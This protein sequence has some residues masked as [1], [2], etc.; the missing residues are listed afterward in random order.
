MLGAIIGDI[1]GSRFEFN[2]HRSKE[3]ELFT[4]ECFVT[5]DSIMTLAVAK[6]LM[7]TEK[8][9]KLDL[10]SS[11]NADEYYSILEKMT[12]TYMQKI[13]R[14]YPNCGYGG[15][16]GHW[17]FSDHPKPYNSFG[18]GAA[19]RISS[20]AFVAKDES[21]VV[22]LSET[23][24]GVTHN[25][26]EGYKGAEATAIAVW[27][28]R[29]GYTKS[30]IRRQINHNYY[31][32]NYTIDEI[33]D[34]YQFNE[35]CQETVPQAIQA[36]L[37]SNSF[38]DAIRIAISVGG[39]SD[40][41]AAIT[42]AIAEAYYGVPKELKEQALKYLDRELMTIF[43]E[44]NDFLGEKE[45]ETFKVLTKY[46]GKFERLDSFEGRGVA[47]DESGNREAYLQIPTFQFNLLVNEFVKEF[48]EFSS[49][50]VV[51]E[52]TRYEQILEKHGFTSSNQEMA[53]VPLD[54]LNE[55]MIL[56]LIMGVIRA[57]R[58]HEGELNDF[59]KNGVMM[60][61]LKKLKDIDRQKQLLEIEEIYLE[62][63]GFGG[64]DSSHVIFNDGTAEIN[65]TPWLKH[66]VKVQ[67]NK[68]E[69]KKFISDFYKIHV[70]Y[71]DAEYMDRDILDGTQWSLVVKEKGCRSTSWN[72]SNMFPPNW[73]QL[74]YLFRIGADDG[75]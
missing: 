55:Q 64:Y 72:G 60:K 2:N 46:I 6:A 22:L 71:W 43:E 75:K 65:V 67:L 42:G 44:W 15:M 37:E 12:T 58:C 68:E 73:D 9:M 26:E 16:F 24:T 34:N 31:R 53:R 20:V 25:H 47:S 13:G 70:E 59:F 35:T 66:P 28:A 50:N 40:T 74:L 21:E 14:R 69:T 57:E 48:Y 4:K 41:L 62:V 11:K 5:D 51:Y 54:G 8:L 17:V 32:L 38:E 36:F 30:E 63:G 18:N 10:I 52:L 33:R 39:D 29:R 45:E 49:A 1:V 56:A 3:F 19:M 27:M 61:W 7:E 23:I